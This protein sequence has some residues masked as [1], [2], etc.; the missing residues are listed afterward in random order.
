MLLRPVR[1][2]IAKGVMSVSLLA[3]AGVNSSGRISLTLKFLPKI[4]DAFL[5]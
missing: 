3:Q 4:V 5:S 1:K 2:A